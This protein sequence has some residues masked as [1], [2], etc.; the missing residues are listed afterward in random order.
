MSEEHVHNHKIKYV[1]EKVDHNFLADNNLHF[2]REPMQFK[3]AVC[4]CGH[5]Y[6]M[7]LLPVGGR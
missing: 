6:A 7:D 3:M 1:R 4:T 2:S 5:R